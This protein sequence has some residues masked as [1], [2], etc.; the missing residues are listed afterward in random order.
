MKAP[1]LPTLYLPTSNT[2]AKIALEAASVATTAMEL[3][4]LP[5]DTDQQA[6][7][8]LALLAPKAP[9][10]QIIKRVGDARLEITRELDTMKS[11]LIAYER[12]LIAPLVEAVEAS[13]ERVKAHKDRQIAA[14]KKAEADRMLKLADLDEM[15]R[16][17]VTFWEAK[18][19]KAMSIQTLDELL[20]M[21]VKVDAYAGVPNAP[22]RWADK[23]LGNEYLDAADD[24]LILL[25]RLITEIAD[26]WDNPEGR[27]MYVEPVATPTLSVAKVATLMDAP[28]EVIQKGMQ[29]V[30]KPAV[31]DWRAVDAVGLVAAL[32]PDPTAV[33]MLEKLLTKLPKGAQV[34]G[35]TW[36]EESR[37]VAR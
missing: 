24:Q 29:T 5:C 20:D 7:A 27:P 36:V 37:L 12:E 22:Q 25:R 14:N 30:L 18:R 35:V 17:L 26:N 33:V 9:A 11:E 2:L 10:G 6:D 21:K 13:R 8:L 23:G 19:R 28:V 3:A 32:L 1:T 31:A 34:L 4:A 16:E 15:Q